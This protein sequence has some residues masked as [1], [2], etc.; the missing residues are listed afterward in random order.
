MQLENAA[1]ADQVSSIAK[2]AELRFAQG[3]RVVMGGGVRE[4]LAVAQQKVEVGLPAVVGGLGR[5][6]AAV[7][8]VSECEPMS[9]WKVL[10]ASYLPPLRATRGRRGF[11]GSASASVA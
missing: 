7:V 1:V 2:T 5:R 3:L 11:C 4:Y 9:G 8:S 6:F 10:V